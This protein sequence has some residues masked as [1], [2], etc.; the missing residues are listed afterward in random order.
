MCEPQI[1]NNFIYCLKLDFT[2]SAA[3]ETKN[4]LPLFGLSQ[5]ISQSNEKLL[6]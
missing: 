6:P 5:E 3:R 4:T 2:I 1:E